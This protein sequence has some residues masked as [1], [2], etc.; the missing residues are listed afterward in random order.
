M[1]P[2]EA[3]KNALNPSAQD[4]LYGTVITFDRKLNSRQIQIN[5]FLDLI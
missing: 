5:S 4:T 3:K 2:N 1:R